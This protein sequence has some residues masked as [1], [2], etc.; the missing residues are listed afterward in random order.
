MQEATD[1]ALAWIAEAA[2]IVDSAGM[3]TPDR[4]KGLVVGR[5][6]LISIAQHG[7]VL[8]GSVIAAHRHLTA[9]G[10]ARRDAA[11]VAVVPI[12]RSGRQR[13]WSR[14]DISDRWMPT[15]RHPG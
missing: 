7:R 4:D 13:S 12:R 11:D 10:A 8:G 9:A 15:R 3:Q 1:T 14:C 2:L 5:L 6:F